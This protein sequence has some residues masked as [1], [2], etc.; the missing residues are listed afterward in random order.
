MLRKYV[1]HYWC[2]DKTS[3]VCVLHVSTALSSCV[4]SYAAVLFGINIICATH[5]SKEIVGI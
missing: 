5:F 4:Y 1:V 2:Q 3:H